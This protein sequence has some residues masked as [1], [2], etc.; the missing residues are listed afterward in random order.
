M[1]VFNTIART[2]GL[3]TLENKAIRKGKIE[4]AEENLN[5]FRGET[6]LLEESKAISNYL[7][8]KNPRHEK[9]LICLAEAYFQDAYQGG[10]SFRKMKLLKGYNWILKAIAINPKNEE[11][12]SL[13][14]LYIVYLLSPSKAE[15]L[16]KG[17]DSWRANLAYGMIAAKNEDADGLE[18]HMTR[19]IKNCPKSRKAFL[20]NHTGVALSM[21]GHKEKSIHYYKEAINIDPDFAWPYYNLGL[22]EEEIGNED[23][24]NE[25]ANEA[26]ARMKFEFA[27]NLENRTK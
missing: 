16:V 5:R 8:M 4:K 18:L 15:Y 9:A 6:R 22:R 14:A 7:L 19:S 12:R 1:I 25:Y 10:L 17:I 21:L 27:S 20:F 24:A 26:L 2:A 23:A 3:F 13:Q 11:V